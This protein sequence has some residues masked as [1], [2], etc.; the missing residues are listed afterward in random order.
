MGAWPSADDISRP[1]GKWARRRCLYIEKRLSCAQRHHHSGHRATH[2]KLSRRYTL[3]A[4]ST[5]SNHLLMSPFSVNAPKRNPFDLF[6]STRH[7]HIS[8]CVAAYFG[9]RTMLTIQTQFRC[10]NATSSPF[11]VVRGQPIRRKQPQMYAETW[12][13]YG[14]NAKRRNPTYRLEM[15]ANKKKAIRLNITESK[16]GSVKSVCYIYTSRD[17]EQ[18]KKYMRRNP[19]HRL[20]HTYGPGLLILSFNTFE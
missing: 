13:R 14:S 2:E 5:P 17:R 19:P 16:Y 7:N 4:Q 12:F 1:M 18:Q 6:L 8:A 3:A 9:G 11:S 15:G 20:T 10:K